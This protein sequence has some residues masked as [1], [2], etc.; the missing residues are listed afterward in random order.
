MIPLDFLIWDRWQKIT[1]WD[2]PLQPSTLA[3]KKPKLM[4]CI[5]GFRQMA[6]PKNPPS[7]ASI[8]R[9]RLGN[10]PYVDDSERQKPPFIRDV[11]IFSYDFPAKNLHF[12]VTARPAFS[13]MRLVDP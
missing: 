3:N 1:Y 13:S 9:L 10:S 7:G 12:S 8:R 2:V 4:Q 6:F 11:A 5:S